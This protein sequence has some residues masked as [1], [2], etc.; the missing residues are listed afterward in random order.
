MKKWC[1]L[2]VV[3]CIPMQT[4]Y[5]QT[6]TATEFSPFFSKVKFQGWLDDGS[7][8]PKLMQLIE[9]VADGTTPPDEMIPRLE[10]MMYPDSKDVNV[11]KKRKT[12]RAVRGMLRDIGHMSGDSILDTVITLQDALEGEGE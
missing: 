4:I 6:L 5:S 2:A 1:V 12:Y 3:I 8:T 10:A 7:N 11:S 9:R